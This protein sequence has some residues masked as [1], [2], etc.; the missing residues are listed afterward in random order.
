L[1]NANRNILKQ[2]GA[3]SRKICIEMA[4]NAKEIFGSDYSISVT[5]YAGP[6]ANDKNVGLVYCCIAGPEKYEKIYKKIFQTDLDIK[7]G[8]IHSELALDMFIAEI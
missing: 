5:G 2:Y 3:V 6:E 1:L 7:S 4:E 8:K